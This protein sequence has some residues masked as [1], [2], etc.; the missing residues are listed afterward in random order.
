LPDKRPVA[1]H[2]NGI[3]LAGAK[4]QNLCSS[5]SAP[6]LDNT[7][8]FSHPDCPCR[9][10]IHVLTGVQW[11]HCHPMAASAKPSFINHLIDTIQSLS[12]NRRSVAGEPRET[13][14]TNIHQN[15]A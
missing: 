5:N 1:T 12:Y 6:F 7:W 9:V 2:E 8:D 4:K 3:V 11:S 13:E 14:P 10:G 15:P